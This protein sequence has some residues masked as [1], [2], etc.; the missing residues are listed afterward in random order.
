MKYTIKPGTRF[1]C[2]CYLCIEENVKW[3]YIVCKKIDSHTY[4]VVFED[5]FNDDFTM[6]VNDIQIINL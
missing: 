2:K 4:L 5:D 6:H 3:N 1:I